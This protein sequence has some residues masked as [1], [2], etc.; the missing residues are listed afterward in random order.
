MHPQLQEAVEVLVNEILNYESDT[1]S[2]RANAVTWQEAKHMAAQVISNA[3]DKY[4][5]YCM[6]DL[7]DNVRTDDEEE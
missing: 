5:G 4:D 3:F 2:S 1:L 7:L 6:Q